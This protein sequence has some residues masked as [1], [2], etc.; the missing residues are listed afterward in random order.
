MILQKKK[1]ALNSLFASLAR[2]IFQPLGLVFFLVSLMIGG[3][4]FSVLASYSA[5]PG[6]SLYIAK[7]INEKTQLALAFNDN[8]K[9]KLGL[10]FAQNRAR[11]ITQLLKQSSLA[12]EEKDKQVEELAQNVKKEI[13]KIDSRLYAQSEKKS[14]ELDIKESESSS[15]GG[16][17][18]VSNEEN[19][20]VFSAY[21]GKAENG[22][23]IFEKTSQLQKVLDEAEVLIDDK[24]YQGTLNKLD[25]AQTIIEEV[26]NIDNYDNIIVDNFDSTQGTSS[27]ALEFNNK[28]SE[29]EIVIKT[30][31]LQEKQATSSKY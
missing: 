1:A 4:I 11:E 3:G 22:M 7:I 6:D 30:E 23:Q 12:S 14:E 28:E 16:S 29:Q 27:N 8:K 18:T 24:D 25:E 2:Q 17:N 10:G 13:N 20:Q 26:E 5:K 15:Q 31:P 9:I 21:L 19:I